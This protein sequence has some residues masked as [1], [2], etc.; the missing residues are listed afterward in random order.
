LLGAENF[1]QFKGGELSMGVLGGFEGTMR[2]EFSIKNSA[3]FGKTIQEKFI[4]WS[5]RRGLDGGEGKISEA[6]GRE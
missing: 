4:G 2:E 1:P 6:G 3:G 5:E